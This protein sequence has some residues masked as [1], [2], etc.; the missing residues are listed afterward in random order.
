[1]YYIRPKSMLLVLGAVQ[2]ASP[3]QTA[4]V[5]VLLVRALVV[6]VLVLMGALPLLPQLRHMLLDCCQV[7]SPDCCC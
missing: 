4:V 5:I 1:M 7:W 2:A 3:A 6:L